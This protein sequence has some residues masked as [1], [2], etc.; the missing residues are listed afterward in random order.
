MDDFFDND[1]TFDASSEALE[2]RW[3]DASGTPAEHPAED[4]S[5]PAEPAAEEMVE[6]EVPDGEPLPEGAVVVEAADEQ[7]AE[8]PDEAADED[9]G[10]QPEPDPEDSAGLPEKY[11]GKS[12]EEIIQLANKERSYFNERVKAIEAERERERAEANAQFEQL[13]QLLA[14]QA[15]MQRQQAMQSTSGQLAEQLSELAVQDPWGA[16]NAARAAVTQGQAA[17]SVVEDVID[18]IH[19]NVDPSMAS[20]MRTMMVREQVQRETKAALEQQVAPL[21][22][23]TYEANATAAVTSFAQEAG[24]DFEEFRAEL[25][26]RMRPIQPQLEQHGATA[27]QI[28]QVLTEQLNYIRGQHPHRTSAYKAALRERKVNER[29][30]VPSAPAAAQREQP[31]SEE[32]QYRQNVLARRDDAV[33]ELMAGFPGM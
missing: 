31:L 14:E 21:R 17:E 18:T 23:Q 10:E 32:E 30:Q 2:S 25:A 28:R 29:V 15:Q 26:E 8:E 13:T 19:V 5:E 33:S 9:G 24:E 3:E 20:H 22:K 7:P 6:V 11:A 27:D 1:D 16:F 4:P 12:P